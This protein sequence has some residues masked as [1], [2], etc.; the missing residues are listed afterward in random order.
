MNSFR[1]C[2]TGAL[3]KTIRRLMSARALGGILTPPLAQDEYDR[4]VLLRPSHSPM[5]FSI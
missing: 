2:H 1:A 3:D 5:S 4:L